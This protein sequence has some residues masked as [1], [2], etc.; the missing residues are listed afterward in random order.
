MGEDCLEG[1][2]ESPARGHCGWALPCTEPALPAAEVGK[3]RASSVS[4][5]TEAVARLCHVTQWQ[6]LS[7]PSSRSSETAAPILTSP[8]QR[9]ASW[10]RSS[11]EGKA[12]PAGHLPEPS[13]SPAPDLLPLEVLS[14]FRPQHGFASLVH[15]GDVRAGRGPCHRVD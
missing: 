12:T 13:A 8:V 6:A 10:F 15:T 2:W 9:K 11:V 14:V 4:H 5:R 3:V 1:W 7:C